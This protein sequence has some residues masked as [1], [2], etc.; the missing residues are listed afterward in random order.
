MELKQ[1]DELV[2]GDLTVVVESGKRYHG[3]YKESLEVVF[4][5]IPD[6]EVI[7]GYIQ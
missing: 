1:I 3:Y 2:E 7:L 5:A 4:F 6:H